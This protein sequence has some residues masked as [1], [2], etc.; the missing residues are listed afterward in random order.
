MTA[1]AGIVVNK[2]ENAVLLPNAALRFTPPAK[3]N[4]T[5]SEN[6]SIIGKLFPRPRRPQTKQK[7]E[8]KADRKKA[9]AWALK[10][11]NLYEIPVM[12]GE[13]D[14][15]MTEVIGGGVETGMKVVVDTIRT[16]Q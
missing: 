3:E 4:E 11:G 16:G 10:D 2:I 7:K 8:T 14:G 1:T 6:S 15:I 12:I 9:K 13:S 5:L